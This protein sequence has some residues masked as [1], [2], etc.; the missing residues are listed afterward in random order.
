M[1]NILQKHEKEN[2]LLSEQLVAFKQ[3]IIESDSFNTSNTK[4]EGL[5]WTAFGKSK[6]TIYFTE[7]SRGG[8]KTE[9]DYFIVIEYGSGKAFKVKLDSLKEFYIIEQTNQLCLTWPEKNL[10]KKIHS[11]TFES[12]EVEEILDKYLELEDKIN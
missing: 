6:A 10:F 11:E 12:T 2:R 3:Q 7:E 1:Q 8:N 5:R 4:Y 9:V